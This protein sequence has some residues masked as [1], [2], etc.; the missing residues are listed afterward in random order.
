MTPQHARA[1]NVDTSRRVVEFSAALPDLVR[2]VHLSGYR[3]GGQDPATVPWSTQRRTLDYARLGAYEARG[4]GHRR[5][6][7]APRRVIPN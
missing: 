6:R 5:F 7:P 1:A 3:I 2:L 4:L